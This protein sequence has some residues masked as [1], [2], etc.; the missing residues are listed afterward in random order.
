MWIICFL[1]GYELLIPENMVKLIF[2]NKK[3]K[4]IK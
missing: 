3:E 4:F 1:L 2:I